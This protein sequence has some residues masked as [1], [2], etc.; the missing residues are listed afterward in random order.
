MF[1]CQTSEGGEKRITIDS[2]K[3]VVVQLHRNGEKVADTAQAVNKSLSSIYRI[4][5]KFQNKGSLEIRQR[6]GR[7]RLIHERDYRRL[8]RIVYVD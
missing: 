6:S 2:F 1:C 3:N 8:Q 5:R 4:I 7:Q